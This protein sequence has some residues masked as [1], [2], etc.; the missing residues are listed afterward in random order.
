MKKFVAFLII[1]V[2]MTAVAIGVDLGYHAD[3]V[4]YSVMEDFRNEKLMEMLNEE[5]PDKKIQLQYISTGTCASRLKAEGKKTN[6]DIVIDL[7]VSYL[8][9]LKDNFADLSEFNNGQYFKQ[10]DV[11][12]NKYLP[13]SKYC[14]GLIYNETVLNNLGI[15]PPKS[16]Q[17]L[18]DE[19]YKGLIY[20]P[21][22]KASSTGYIFLKTIIQ[23]Y[24][25]DKA[26]EYFDKLNKNVKQY[27]SSG[28]AP[29]N[30]VSRGEG[31]IAIGLVFSAVQQINDGINLKIVNLQE[32]VGY[33]VSGATIIKG[34]EKKEL[35]KDVFRFINNE[36][37]DYDKYYFL[38]EQIKIDNNGTIIENFPDLKEIY[39]T[40]INSVE[41]RERILKLWKF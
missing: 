23:L 30:Q 22:P 17:D 15:D 26:L 5:F 18:L 38:P 32:G 16:Y 28:S 37:V 29:L 14:Y 41:C 11:G 27:T 25:E 34:R 2:A 33:G 4:I 13:T 24:G 12:N 35:V 9:L 3:V 19:K 7:D 36:F 1:L 10:Y 39:M 20:I 6:A 8:E 21:D 40:D 31:G